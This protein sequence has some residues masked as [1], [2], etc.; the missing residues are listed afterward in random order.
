MGS[1]LNSTV[2]IC[3]APICARSG[4]FTAKVSFE[5]VAIIG[6][7]ITVPSAATLSNSGSNQP[8]EEQSGFFK[9]IKGVTV[10]R[11]IGILRYHFA[12]SIYRY[13]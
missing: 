5:I 1:H 2:G 11:Y 4:L 10:Y 3:T 8:R 7:T 12:D 6:A 13:A 9:G